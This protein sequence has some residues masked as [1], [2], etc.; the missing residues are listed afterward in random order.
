MPML[1]QL[2]IALGA[3]VAVVAVALVALVAFVDVNRF[4]PQIAQTVKDRYDRT[5]AI[6]GDLSLAVFPRI[7][8]ALPRTTLSEH[9]GKETFASVDGARVSVALLPL[10][11]GR[12]EAGKVSIYGLTATVEKRADGSTNI[13]DLLGAPKTAPPQQP[14]KEA[15]GPPQ[16]E[17]GGVELANATLTYRDL[18]AKNVVTLSKLNVTTGRIATASRTPLDLSTAFAATNPV[19]QGELSAKGGA[20]ID[21]VKKVFG[22][23]DLALKLRATVDKRALEFDG[24]V[25]TASFDVASGAL[26]AGKLTATAKG[27]FDGMAL[28]DAKIDAPALAWDPKAKRLS[29]GGVNLTARGRLPGADGKPGDAFDAGFAAPKIEITDTS[30]SGDRVTASVKLVGANNVDARLTLEGLSGSA[31]EMKIGRL[32]LAA[33]AQQPIVKDGKPTQQTRLVVAN[34]ASPAT[35]SL[36]AQTFALARLDG[37]ITV[38]DPALPQKTVK[39]PVSGA[40]SVD[41]KKELV[42]GRFSTRFDETTLSSE[43]DVRGFSPPAIG[44]EASADKLNLDRYFPPAKPAPGNDSA[45]PKDDPKVD[46]SALKQLR[47]NGE[48]RIGQLQAR[49]IRTQNLRVVLKAA[50]GRLDVAPLTAALY[51]GN[52][53]AS[54][55][56][57]ADGNRIAAAAALTGVQ[58]EPLLKDALNKDVLAGRGNVKLDVTTAGATVNGLKRGLNG[59][60]ALQLRDGAVKGIN[61][62]GTLRNARSFLGGGGE[63]TETKTGSAAEKTDFSEMTASFAIKDGV[64]SSDDLDLKSPLIRVGGAGQVDLAAGTLDYTVKAAVVGTLKGQDGRDMNELKGLTIPVKLAGPFEKMAYTVDWGAVAQDALKSKVAEQ[65]K[66]KLAPQVQEQRKK[67]EERARDA[68]KGLLG[69]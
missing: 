37:E 33:T 4:K 34:I 45:D 31:K 52:V 3:I 64:V 5:L 28:E 67:V 6:E 14:Q 23:T 22:A 18:A 17:I 43:F 40:L 39:L 36:E 60:G 1:K 65:A 7:A 56:A 35:A 50:N 9:G 2:L 59:S 51:S 54:L 63:K 21:L 53:N 30:A 20:D 29:L 8:V 16:F 61:I 24:K 26:S 44:F 42:D 48:A 32:A 11:G 57:Q 62:A 47:I 41:A 46:L 13:D 49:G 69:R 10:L 19:A 25:G 27:A 68:L 66:E 12:I 55:S 15:G 38:E 58:I